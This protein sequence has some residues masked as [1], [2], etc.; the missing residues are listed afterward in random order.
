[1]ELIPFPEKIVKIKDTAWSLEYDPLKHFFI[2][3]PFEYSFYERQLKMLPR[4]GSNCGFNLVCQ[5]SG[6]II[7]SVK[8]RA[9]VILRRDSFGK[10]YISVVKFSVVTK[11]GK[12]V[13]NHTESFVRA[14]L[15]SSDLD[16]L[17]YSGV[18]DYL[19]ECREIALKNM[20]IIVDAKIKENKLNYMRI[21]NNI[22]SEGG[23]IWELEQ[24]ESL[25]H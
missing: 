11:N 4:E 22:Q 16:H 9:V 18:R 19:L 21:V 13:D 3:D 7:D 6:S 1:M 2:R 20:R 10:L 12:K 14:Y 17:F 25:E 15:N 23:L 5:N 24:W 8:T